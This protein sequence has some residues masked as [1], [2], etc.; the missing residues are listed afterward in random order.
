MSSNEKQI[1]E[2]YAF[3]KV[4]DGRENLSRYAGIEFQFLLSHPLTAA[5]PSHSPEKEFS[6]LLSD[7]LENAIIAA[8]SSPSGTVQIHMG[9]FDKIY[10][11]KVI[12]TGNPF[13][14]EVLQDLGINRHTTHKDSGGSGI[15][16]MDIWKI[17]EDYSAT[18]LID[19][20]TASSSET[21]STTINILFNNRN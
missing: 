11:L 16:L 18:L 3:G 9:M 8:K 19:E 6:H 12:N 20:I 5:I 17:K 1:L 13:P 4:E 14:I 2:S 10:T 7:L 15:G 21:T